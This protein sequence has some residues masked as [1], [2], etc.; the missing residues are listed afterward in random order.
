[1]S[2]YFFLSILCQL[3]DILIVDLSIGI[4]Y[5]Q[6]V[7]KENFSNFPNLSGKTNVDLLECTKKY[8]KNHIRSNVIF[9]WATM[10]FTICL[11]ILKY[12]IPRDTIIVD[13]VT[14][15]RFT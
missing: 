2:I 6:P 5:K 1:M 13:S 4:C 3:F 11:N 9:C 14:F 12:I 7:N 15:I 10:T 8:V